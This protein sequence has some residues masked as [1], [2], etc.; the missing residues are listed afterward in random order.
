MNKIEIGY[1]C[2]LNKTLVYV[3]RII[4]TMATVT[5]A[6]QPTWHKRVPVCKLRPTEVS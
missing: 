4:G 2:Y 3:N 6:E 1:F 5:Y